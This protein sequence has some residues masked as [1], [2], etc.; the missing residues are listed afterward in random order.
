MIFFASTVCFPPEIMECWVEK[1][2]QRKLEVVVHGFS[3]FKPIIPLLQYSNC[4]ALRGPQDQ[5]SGVQF[6]SPTT[7]DKSSV[8]GAKVCQDTDPF[9]ADAIHRG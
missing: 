3:S 5:L 1:K 4:G 6:V 2:Q 8:F 9:P 7:P